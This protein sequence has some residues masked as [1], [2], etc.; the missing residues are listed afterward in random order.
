MKIRV[1]VVD[2]SVTIRAMLDSVFERDPEI[3]VVGEAADA[4]QAMTMIRRLYPDVVTL[5]IA[6]PGMDGIALL[7]LILATTKAHPVML[8]GRAEAR[9]ESMDHGALGFFDKA[10]IIRRAP[11]LRRL[12]KRAAEGKVQPQVQT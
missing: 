8:S 12:I 1:L 11:E 5:D 7:D 4:A 6:M 2:D 3:D 10:Q 9:C